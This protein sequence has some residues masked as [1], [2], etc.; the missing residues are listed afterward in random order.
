M[1]LSI[2]VCAYNEAATIKK[3]LARLR[4]HPIK[5]CHRQII[6][7]DN[8]STDG[9]REIIKSFKGK[10]FKK[11]F[12][13]RNLG[14]GASIRSGI[15][16]ATGDY[17]LIQ[18]ADLE[19]HPREHTKLVNQARQ[20]ALAIYGS[21]VLGRSPRYHYLHT[22]WGVKFLTAL[23]N[24]LY[25]AHLTDVATAMKLVKTDLVKRLGLVCNG[26]D[27][28]F[29]L[30]NKLLSYGVNIV[31]VPINYTPRTYAAGKKITFRDGLKAL[32]VIIKNRLQSQPEVYTY[33]K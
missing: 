21:R 6:F 16:H 24:W 17:I 31:E 9:T 32:K 14:K 27:L 22:Y 28:D 3:T 29:E 15:A 18:D 2:I 25:S 20:G 4:R 1:K 26:F 7:V 13:S 5:N 19:Y 33:K 23:T 30:T 12:H 11:I 10:S 8:A